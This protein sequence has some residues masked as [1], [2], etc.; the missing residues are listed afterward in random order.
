MKTIWTA[1]RAYTTGSGE[2]GKGWSL[3]AMAQFVLPVKRRASAPYW[4]RPTPERISAIARKR[5][6][7]R[8]SDRMVI[9]KITDQIGTM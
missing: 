8:G 5:L 1:E 3:S 4:L 9:P 6:G 7:G 2:P